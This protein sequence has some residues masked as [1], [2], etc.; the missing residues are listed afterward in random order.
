[1]SDLP[2]GESRLATRFEA[3]VA[4]AG[5]A[6]RADWLATATSEPAV[7]DR[8][9]DLAAPLTE[10]AEISAAAYQDTLSDATR[11]AS[12]HFATDPAVATALCRW[13]IQQRAD[14]LAP[15]VLDPATGSGVFTLA[16]HDRIATVAPNQSPTDRLEGV[17]GVDVD[18]VA[19]ALT[20]HRL[21]ANA[22]PETAGAS[23]AR[24]N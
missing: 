11:T 23:N 3:V 18:P 16:A 21:L 12:G 24:I 15:R 2:S 4:A 19:L 7:R 17:V 9:A 5:G 13:A 8:L 1:M 22:S 10:G 14:G 20:G 6:T